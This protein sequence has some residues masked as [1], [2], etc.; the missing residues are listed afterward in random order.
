MPEVLHNVPTKYHWMVQYPEGLVLGHGCDIG[1]FTYINARY[2]VEIGEDAQIGSHTSI[3]S[4]STIDGKM[5][6]VKLGAGAC[7]GSHCT[8][9]PGVSIGEGAIVGAHSFV[10]GDIPPRAV[11]FGVPAKVV[12]F[13]GRAANEKME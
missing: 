9:M 8:I 13:Q 2:G 11:A 12:R 7:V 5:G 3:Y 4:V 10:N 6:P 1:A